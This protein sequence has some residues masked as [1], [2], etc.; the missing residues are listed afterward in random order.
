MFNK[1][2]KRKR[3]RFACKVFT[4]SALALARSMPTPGFNRF[5]NSIPSSRLVMDA[6]KNQTIAFTANAANRFKISEFGNA[7][8]KRAENE[9]CNNH[10][11]Q[12][13]GK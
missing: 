13:S 8:N 7:H 6:D 10:F 4:L 3:L 11:A 1:I 2:L 9:W 12:A 5:T